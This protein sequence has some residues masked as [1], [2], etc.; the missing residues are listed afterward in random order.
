M[1]GVETSALVG[2]LQTLGQHRHNKNQRRMTQE[3]LASL[4]NC[5]TFIQQC[6]AKIRLS[7]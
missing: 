3:S 4:F 6:A 7:G 1:N 2:Y 5:E